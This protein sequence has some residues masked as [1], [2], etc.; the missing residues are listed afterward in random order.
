MMATE[1]TQTGS[2]GVS[3]K[4]IISLILCS[5]NDQYQ[6]NSV[7][8]LQTALNYVAQNVSEL[9]KEEQVEVIVADWSSEIPLRNVLKLT[10]QA[11][12][13]VSF[14]HIPSEIARVEQKDS[15]FPEVL[16]LNAAARRANGEYI[17]RIDQDTLVGKH[18]LEK[19]FWLHEKRRLIVHLNSAV[20]LSNRRRI[21][22]RFAAHCPSFWIVDRYLRWFGRFLPLMEPP[23][24][25]LYYQCYI[26]ILLFHRDLWHQ[27]GGYDERFIYMDYME[28][29]IIFRLT[30]QNVFVNLG[31]IV[32]HDFYHLDHG[33]PRQ[34]WS[35]SRNRKT[36]PI[37][38]LDNLPEEIHP[39]GQDWGL[40]QYPLEVLPYPLDQGG[41]QSRALYPSRFKWLT[42]I[43]QVSIS[44]VQIAW[45]KMLYSL[46]SMGRSMRWSIFAL[47]TW[48]N[49]ARVV[50]ETIS[51]QP[52]RSWPRLL[53]TRWMERRSYRS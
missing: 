36:N 33:H 29:D 50:R 35:A 1:N 28:F 10:P 20:L 41:A 32:D 38:D 12:R 6:G 52:L 18:F 42:F 43:F 46:T 30:T 23:P 8:R 7:W 25:H 48:R 19:F 39:N 26:G 47:S 53:L 16:A 34:P 5:R 17:G 24:S 40:N 15:P 4:P 22:Y 21:P 31:E 2:V 51:G 13:I 44:G 3:K 27:C 45:D 14:L 49:R 37:R 9:G 11:A